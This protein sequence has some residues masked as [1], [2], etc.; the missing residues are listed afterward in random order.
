MTF[1][2]IKK[3]IGK[4]LNDPDLKKYRGVLNNV[5]TQSMCQLIAENKYQPEDI[6]DLII[7]DVPDDDVVFENYEASYELPFNTLKFLDIYLSTASLM[8]TP[9][10]LKEVDHEEIKRIQLE[11]AFAPTHT[12]CF[13]YR[14]GK[15]VKFVLSK[16]FDP[17]EAPNSFPFIYSYIEN[18][19]PDEWDSS[20]DLIA[21]IGYSR[22]FLYNCIDRSLGMLGGSK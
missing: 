19:D 2:D 5:F 21:D 8:T 3:E 15:E 9:L 16:D 6:P 10:T 13:W 7:D 1:D 18:P 17:D 22:D 4:R 11:P 14:K 20:V 12:E